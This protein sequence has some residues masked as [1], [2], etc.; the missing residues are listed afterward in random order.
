MV[1]SGDSGMD[2]NMLLYLT[3]RTNKDLLFSTGTSAQSSII[4]LWSPG[5]RMGEG[6]VREFG[7]DMDTLLYLTGRSNRDLLDSTG[8]S[9]QC[10]EAAWM[11]GEFGG[12]WI[13]VCVAES[14]CCPTETV[15]TLLTGH[16]PIQNKLQ[17]N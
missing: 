15:T 16:T 4:P 7:M 3:W 8:H 6:I 10:H 1:P 14:L 17:D 9:A 12:E 2:M 11:G 13:C 5:G